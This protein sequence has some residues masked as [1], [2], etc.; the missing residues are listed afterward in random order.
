MVCFR[1]DIE[2][3]CPFTLISAAANCNGNYWGVADIFIWNHA[4]DWIHCRAFQ[5][6]VAAHS[7]SAVVSEAYGFE[8]RF[9]WFGVIE[10]SSV[11][12]HR[13]GCKATWSYC[14]LMIIDVGGL[15]EKCVGILKIAFH[16]YLIV[17]HFKGFI[18]GDCRFWIE[19]ESRNDAVISSIDIFAVVRPAKAIDCRRI[20]GIKSRAQPPPRSSAVTWTY[21]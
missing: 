3:T 11:L 17:N 1:A 16:R 8:H 7:F 6:S 19:F 12:N 13:R 9:C 21:I 5:I 18:L 14:E 10:R 15:L 4:G 20:A 2:V